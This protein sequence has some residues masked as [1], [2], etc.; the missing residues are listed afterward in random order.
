M[1]KLIKK[2][3][4]GYAGEDIIVERKLEDGMWKTTTEN[5]SNR[6][7][8][9]QISNTAIVIG[10]GITRTGFDLQNFKKASGL[11]GAKTVQTYGC[12]A[13]YRDF[14]PDFLVAVG[15]NGIVDEIA[16]RGYT[17]EHITYS[18]AI[19]LLEF[20]GK[21]Y[22]IPHDIYAM[23]VLLLLIWPRLMNI[24]KYTY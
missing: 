14:N 13:L 15:N 10:N 19:H 8:N 17:N 23:Q 22:L 5:V 24:K 18:S 20:P 7:S 3:R 9:R 16:D 1:L 21:F 12:N 6:I 2:V 11:L 4:R